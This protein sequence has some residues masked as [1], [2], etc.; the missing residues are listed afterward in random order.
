MKIYVLL[1]LIGAIVSMSY[2]PTRQ[3][4]PAAAP[5]PDTVPANA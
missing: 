2:I 3:T 5:S 4:K 1:I